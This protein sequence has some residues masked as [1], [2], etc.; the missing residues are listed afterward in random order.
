MSQAIIMTCIFIILIL[1]ILIVNN[2]HHIQEGRGF[3]DLIRC[4]TVENSRF[5]Q[6]P[7]DVPFLQQL[8]ISCNIWQDLCEMLHI[9]FQFSFFEIYCNSFRR[10]IIYQQTLIP[11]TL[12]HFCFFFCFSPFYYDEGNYYFGKVIIHH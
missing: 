10:V 11:I 9:Y 1:I 2:I 3:S 4:K 6:F 12:Q 8:T 7:R 5:Y